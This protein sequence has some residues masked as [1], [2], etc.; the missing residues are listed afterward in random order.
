M[1][2]CQLAAWACISM[3]MNYLSVGC[4]SMYSNDDELFVSWLPERVFQWWWII[5]QLA[6]WA[7]IPTI[8]SNYSL[9]NIEDLLNTVHYNKTLADVTSCQPPPNSDP[10]K[11]HPSNSCLV[12]KTRLICGRSPMSRDMNPSR[13]S[14]YTKVCWGISTRHKHSTTALIY[15]MAGVEITFLSGGRLTFWHAISFRTDIRLII[16]KSTGLVHAFATVH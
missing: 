10:D 1:N 14:S 2:Y 11:M 4:L 7:C 6:A 8:N 15:K 12:L 16:S 9:Q 5:C 3:M 13:I